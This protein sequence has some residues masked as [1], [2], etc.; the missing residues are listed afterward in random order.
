MTAAPATTCAKCAKPICGHTDA[1]FA[2]TVVRGDQSEPGSWARALRHTEHLR[3]K[4]T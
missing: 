3:E 4:R 2:G 1:I